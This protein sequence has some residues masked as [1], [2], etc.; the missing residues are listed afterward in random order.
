[1]YQGHYYINKSIREYLD[2][3]YIAYLDDIL[4]FSKNKEE[5]IK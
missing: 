5:H 3:F 4:V 1:M 2:I